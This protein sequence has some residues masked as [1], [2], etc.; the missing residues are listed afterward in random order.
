MLSALVETTLARKTTKL[1]ASTKED[2]RTLKALAGEKVR[3]TGIAPRKGNQ[4]KRGV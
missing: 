4:A 3:T 1:R 2:V